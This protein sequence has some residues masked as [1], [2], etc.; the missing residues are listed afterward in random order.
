MKK[1]LIVFCLLVLSFPAL[2]GNKELTLRN[3]AYAS[4]KSDYN[5]IHVSGEMAFYQAYQSVLIIEKYL[6]KAGIYVPYA[7][8]WKAA[9][10]R[11]VRSGGKHKEFT[12]QEYIAFLQMYLDLAR[13]IRSV[14]D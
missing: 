2:A 9:F 4:A 14:M 7:R 13:T 11:Q 10:R 12:D 5:A 6:H 1:I 8:Y 3:I